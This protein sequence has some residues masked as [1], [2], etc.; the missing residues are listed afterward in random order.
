MALNLIE[1]SKRAAGRDETYLATIMELY[2]RGSLLLQ[3]TP[4]ED[5]SGN[6]ITFNQE[7][8]LP[9][10]AFRGINEAYTEG[11][12]TTT[13]VTE[14]LAI[15]GGDLDVDVFIVK[16]GGS[17]ARAS[18]EA[19]KIKALSLSITKTMITGNVATAPKSFNGLQTRLSTVGDQ[20]LQNAGANNALSL[21]ELDRLID[22]VE[23]PTN[24]IM[25]KTMRRRLTAAARLYTVGGY[26]T[27][28]L[29]AFG[30]RVT[31][32][33]DLPIL[34]VDKDESNDDI[35]TFEETDIE[36]AGTADCSSIYCVSM[37][38]N[39]FMGLQSEEMSVRDLGEIDTKPV[40]RTRIEWYVTISI[41]RPRAAARLNSIR[42]YPVV[43]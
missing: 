30:R 19:M 8:G 34:E 11:T 23:D 18:E 36:G 12:G 29:D 7:Q 35:M 42:D 39:G 20:R 26:I 25:N 33:N 22:A 21:T 14:T 24:L 37:S 10:I 41:R 27:Y 15:A 40:F 17:D 13:K 28:D 32:F 43:A 6:A 4:F 31:K 38:D 3:Y 5:I 2:A 16:T 1:A 9:A